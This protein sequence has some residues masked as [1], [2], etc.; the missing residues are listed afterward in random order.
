VIQSGAL[1]RSPPGGQEAFPDACPTSGRAGNAATHESARGSRPDQPRSVPVTSVTKGS[2]QVRNGPGLGAVA[3][4]R[5]DGQPVRS[6]PA[7]PGSDGELAH[8]HD[9][10]ITTDTIVPIGLADKLDLD[11]AIWACFAN[12]RIDAEQ[13]SQQR[14]HE[15]LELAACPAR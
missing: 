11:L 4:T 1:T 15:E 5:P 8:C 6:A 7:L 9:A 12:A 10:H 13:V 14:D 3:F 2:A